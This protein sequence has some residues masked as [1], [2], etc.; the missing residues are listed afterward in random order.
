M[1]ETMRL[2]SPVH[3]SEE[4]YELSQQLSRQ[5]WDII[6]SNTVNFWESIE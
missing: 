6:M 3:P 5:I 1:D 4:S 2:D